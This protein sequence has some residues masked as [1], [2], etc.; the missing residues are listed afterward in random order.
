MSADELESY[1]AE[2]DVIL[3][4]PGL[5][6]RD[7][8]SPETKVSESSSIGEIEQI[9]DEGVLTR[10]LTNKLLKKYKEKKWVIDAGAL[11]ELDK[12]NITPLCVLTP[13]LG[14]FTRLFPELKP[15][16][17]KE[18]NVKL[19]AIFE[20][21][22]K[23]YPATWLLKNKGVDYI[24]SGQNNAIATVVKGGNEGLTKGGTGDVLAALTAAFYIKNNPVTAASCASFIVKKAADFLYVNQGPYFS[25]T[26]LV[27]QIPKS[28]HS[29]RLKTES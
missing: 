27:E 4:G 8:N 19:E 20:K 22:I 17:E 13:H 24:F 11:Q 29:L 5:C 10:I 6:R 14:E 9:Q 7:Q 15:A 25:T 21:V 28:L 2:A 26:Q 23:D 12:V 18:E 1:T 16:I 3:I